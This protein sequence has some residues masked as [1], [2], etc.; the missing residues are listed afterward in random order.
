MMSTGEESVSTFKSISKRELLQ[1]LYDRGST[2]L[3]SANY[4]Q[5]VQDFLLERFR[6]SPDS[7]AAD[8]V[9]A[10]S[11]VLAADVVP[12]AAVVPAAAD[13]PVSCALPSSRVAHWT[14]YV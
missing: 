14:G 6:I 10:G 11:V 1:S 7:E 12:V 8:V 3:R 2:P 13:G 9:H 5:D 4:T